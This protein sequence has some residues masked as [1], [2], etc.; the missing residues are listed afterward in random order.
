MRL[1]ILIT[2]S[3]KH[4]DQSQEMAI[5]TVV[6]W[7]SSNIFVKPLLTLEMSQNVLHIKIHLLITAF[8]SFIGS[9]ILWKSSLLLISI[10]ASWALLSLYFLIEK[11]FYSWIE[12]PDQDGLEYN[13]VETSVLVAQLIF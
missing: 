11:T 7:E 5:V 4:Y 10:S 3:S 9:S 12:L 8:G 1:R 6:S 13:R 2:C